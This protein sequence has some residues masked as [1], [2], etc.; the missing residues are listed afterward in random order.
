M[1]PNASSFVSAGMVILAI[2]LAGAFVVAWGKAAP[3]GTPSNRSYQLGGLVMAVWL[4][5]CAALASSG[6]LAR[7]DQ[8]PPPLGLFL[9]MV[10]GAALVLGFSPVGRRVADG[11]PFWALIGLQSFRLPLELV[12]HEA[13]RAGIMPVQMSFSGWNFDIVTG[14]S[15]VVVALLARKGRA[16]RGWLRAWNTLGILLL[17]NILAIAIASTPVFH[18]FGTDPARLNTWVA[19]FPYVWL[20]G[21]LVPAAIFGHVVIAR[22]LAASVVP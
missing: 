15:A 2:T 4:G 19:Y 3:A 5:C 6:V 20:P 21:V 12:M 7:F 13:A 14:A 1:P 22:K 11:L 9:L 17:L 16:S 8:R 18:A 10:F